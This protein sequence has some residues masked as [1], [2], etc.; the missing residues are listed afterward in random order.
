MDV[1]R[2]DPVRQW[3]MQASG[4]DASSVTQP[5]AA[6]LPAGP[7]NDHASLPAFYLPDQVESKPRSNGKPAYGICSAAVWLCSQVDGSNKR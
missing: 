1:M 7:P 4:N 6:S 3:L 5:E 2:L